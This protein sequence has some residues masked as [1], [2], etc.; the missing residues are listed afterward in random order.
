MA[1]NFALQIVRALGGRGNIA[2]LDAC[3]TR[4]RVKLHDVAKAN[5]EKL[6]ALGAAGV[7]TVGD[8]VQVIFGTQ[9][10]NLKTDIQEYLKIAGPEADK[11]EEPSPVNAPAAAGTVSK[12]RDPDAARKASAIILAL[13]GRE[14]IERVDACAAT[15]L[16]AVLRD[17]APLDESA[18]RMAGIMGLVKL[19]GNV[20]QLIAGANAGQYAAEMS[21]QLAS[22]PLAVAA[23][24]RGAQ[25]T[26][27]HG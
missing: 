11:I 13:G 27:G 23:A 21:G 8:G 5:P 24:S 22:P 25:N 12:L 18:A 1:E 2:A 20:V 17:S 9:A 19:P 10:E 16:R 15:R 7:V 26:N 4:L 6:K 3:I 14:N